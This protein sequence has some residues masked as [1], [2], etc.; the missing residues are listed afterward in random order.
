MCS[1]NDTNT[2]FLSSSPD[3]IEVS[4]NTISNPNI[5]NEGALSTT[6]NN[7][8]SSPSTGEGSHHESSRRSESSSSD[9]P[10]TSGENPGTSSEKDGVHEGTVN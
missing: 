5:S 9:T 2:D 4:G 6:D 8:G 3:N 7:Q 1:T 10:G